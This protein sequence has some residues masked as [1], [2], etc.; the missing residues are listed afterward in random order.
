MEN[1][2]NF[3]LFQ[4][5][6]NVVICSISAFLLYQVW[7]VIVRKK[8]QP[9]DKGGL[10]LAT[11][12][13][14]WVVSGALDLA[15]WKY[16]A[17]LDKSSWPVLYILLRSWL[18]TGNSVF[19]LLALHHFDLAPRWFAGL[20]RHP[21]WKRWVGGTGALV[22][23]LAGVSALRLVLGEQGGPIDASGIFLWDFIFSTFTSIV[24]LVMIRYTLQNQDFHRLAWLGFFLIGII[25]FAQFLDLQIGNTDTDKWLV[26]CKYFFLN[27]YKALL[28]ILF[29]LLLLSWA[30]RAPV[31]ETVVVFTEEEIC[32]RYGLLPRDLEMLRRLARGETREA[33]T[34]VLFPGKT[35]RE[36][37][38]DRQRELAAKF[39][40]PNNVVAILIFALKNGVIALKD[41]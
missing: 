38:D 36:A 15:D 5:L 34:P 2:P 7:R 37:I 32:Q 41:C 6:W 16:S 23:V 17:V 14:F 30:M 35:G 4:G 21:D 8:K 18:S 40:V 28:L 1:Q 20:L 39:R 22:M 24:L 11:S 33:I 13:I 29:A 3:Q 12:L 9:E 19:I 25:L 26:F 10:Y 31:A 27:I